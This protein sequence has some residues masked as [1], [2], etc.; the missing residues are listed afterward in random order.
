MATT[1]RDFLPFGDIDPEMIGRVAEDRN[2]VPVDELSA[3]FA[4]G[5]AAVAMFETIAE[6]LTTN[7]I[8]PAKWRLLM[9][10][11]YQAGPK[12]ASISEIASHLEIREPTVSANV[13]RAVRDGLVERHKDPDDRRINRV[14]LTEAGHETIEAMFPLVLGRLLAFCEDAGGAGQLQ[15]MARHIERGTDTFR[16]RSN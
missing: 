16:E 2:G 9:T 7:G 4:L 11:R 1:I 3:V 13:D 15:E 14:T 12:G 5:K 6:P 8:S 10:L